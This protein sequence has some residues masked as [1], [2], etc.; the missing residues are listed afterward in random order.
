[1]EE[2]YAAPQP[3]VTQILYELANTLQEDHVCPLRIV[4]EQGTPQ[5]YACRVY[6]IRDTDYEGT[7]LSFDE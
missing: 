7:I 1:M 5:I 2:E 4:I 3:T 6:P